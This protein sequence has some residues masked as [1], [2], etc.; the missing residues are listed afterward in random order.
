MQRRSSGSRL[1]FGLP[2]QAQQVQRLGREVELLRSEV[3]SQQLALAHAAAERDGAR[4]GAAEAQERL[5]VGAPIAT[6]GFCPVS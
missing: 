5:K 3:A 4:S 1:S 2:V 6:H